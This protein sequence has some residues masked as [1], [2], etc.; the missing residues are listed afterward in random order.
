[1]EKD[2][3]LLIIANQ[4]KRKINTNSIN[5]YLKS[6]LFKK[7]YQRQRLI[8]EVLSTERT[9]VILMKQLTS[10]YITPLK[11]NM[12]D[13]KKEILNEK[14]FNEIFCNIEEIK[15]INTAFL[16]DLE[17]ELKKELP[18]ISKVFIQHQQKFKNCKINKIKKTP[19]M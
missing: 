13:K 9:Y 19:T 12:K 15:D 5:N 2:Q 17:K 16:K 8:K 11:E 14:E 7:R 18:N 4:F 3:A 6:D 1:M 10:F